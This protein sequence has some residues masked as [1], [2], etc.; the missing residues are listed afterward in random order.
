LTILSPLLG[1][2]P[3]MEACFAFFRA[4]TSNPVLTKDKRMKKEK[5]K[6]NN[7]GI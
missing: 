7:Y 5:K 2:R 4:L 6:S 1:T 3:D